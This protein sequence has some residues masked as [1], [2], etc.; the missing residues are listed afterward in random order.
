[1]HAFKRSDQP[2]AL[3]EKFLPTPSCTPGTNTHNCTVLT[4]I[5][6]SQLWRT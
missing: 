1:M 5:L 2:A 3:Q 4:I 6:Q